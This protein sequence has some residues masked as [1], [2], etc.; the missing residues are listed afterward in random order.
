M[1]FKKEL[2]YEE[3][4]KLPKLEMRE[5]LAWLTEKQKKVK[6]PEAEVS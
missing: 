5:Y 2:L 3:I 1:T 6:K 4:A